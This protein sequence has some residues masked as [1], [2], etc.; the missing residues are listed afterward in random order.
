MRPSGKLSGREVLPDQARCSASQV[1][2]GACAACVV[3]PRPNYCT[4]CCS[5]SG[6]LECLGSE[7]L[8]LRALGVLRDSTQEVM[9]VPFGARV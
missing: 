3:I 1:E 4:L 7:T 6:Q 2:G 8:M 5:A 9:Q